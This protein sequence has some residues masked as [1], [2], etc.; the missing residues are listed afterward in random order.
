MPYTKDDD[1]RLNNFAHEPQMYK[2]DPMSEGQKR[3]FII[4]GSVGG[5]LVLGLVIVAAVV[6]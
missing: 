3:T 6:S 2:V 1:G 5:L 4:L